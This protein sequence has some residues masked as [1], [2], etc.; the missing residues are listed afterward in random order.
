M[1]A[2]LSLLL[3]VI[4]HTVVIYLFLALGLALLGRALMAQFTVLEYL[5]VALLGSAVE[6]GL[7]AGS[8]TVL[9]GLASVATLLVLNRALSLLLSRS[10]RLRRLV[11]NSPIVLAAHGRLLPAQLRRAGL[12]R[13][14]V[15]AAIRQRGYIGLA[16]TRWVVLEINGTVNVIARQP[17]IR[18]D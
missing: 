12:T 13:A 6:T 10:A 5:G 3:T 2:A 9:A 4:G 11:V 18:Q 14:E 15:I 1:V 8:S 17:Q 16:D 7:Y